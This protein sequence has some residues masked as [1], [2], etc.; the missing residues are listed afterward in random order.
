MMSALV[1]RE[2]AVFLQATARTCA[3][4]SARGDSMIRLK[5][6]REL[7]QPAPTQPAAGSREAAAAGGAAA[8]PAAPAADAGTAAEA[9]S[10]PAAAAAAEPQAGLATPKPSEPRDSAAG[11]KA[12]DKS[13][14]PKSAAKPHKKLVPSNFVEVI[15]ALLDVVMGYAGSQ[16]ST[17]QQQQAAA[18]AGPAGMD[19]DQQSP[20]QQPADAAAPAAAPAAAATAAAPAAA[21]D[22]APLPVDLLLRKL[23]PVVR[24]VGIQA[25]VLRLLGDYCLLYNNTV[26]LLLKRD[27][28]AGPAD[29]RG[30]HH[31]TP[32]PL[33]ASH[34]SGTA[35]PADGRTPARR[36]SSRHKEHSSSGGQESHRAGVVLKHI[37]HVQLVDKLPAWGP[38]ANSVSANASALLQAVCIRSAE[39][40]RRILNELVST[41]NS[42]IQGPQKQQAADGQDGAA[43]SGPLPATVSSQ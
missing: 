23:N 34:S 14:P 10:E 28:E 40:R 2:P 20:R 31:S 9:A 11:D 21:G 1:Q 12:G 7:Q 15:D 33:Q 6:A 22:A 16:S 43:N 4:D 42:S 17:Q 37:L 41:L 19:V 35:A 39:G 3:L 30:S 38:S 5:T 25:L 26:G 13:A 8:A 27:N 29:Q 24:E 36:S 18:A 32:G